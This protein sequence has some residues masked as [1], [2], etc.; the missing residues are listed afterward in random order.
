MKIES[1]KKALECD[2]KDW[3]SV[4][5]RFKVLQSD[6]ESL[7]W[8]VLNCIDTNNQDERPKIKH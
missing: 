7:Y 2:P 6:L 5:Q 1:D 3:D 4:L 8:V